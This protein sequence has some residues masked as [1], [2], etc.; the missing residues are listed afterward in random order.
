VGS[1]SCECPPGTVVDENHE[2]VDED[3]CE[4]GNNSCYNGRCVNM[5]PGYSCICQ[6]GFISTQDRRS[7]LDGRQGTCFTSFTAAGQCV[8]DMSSILEIYVSPVH[9]GEPVSLI[10]FVRKLSLYCL[11]QILMSALYARISVIMEFVLT[12]TPDIVVSVRTDTKLPRQ[13]N[14]RIRT[15]V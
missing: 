13:D 1:F 8:N 7:C 4:T 2:C 10:F 15:N 3:E 12:Q 14:V 6:P 5:D 9:P 11:R